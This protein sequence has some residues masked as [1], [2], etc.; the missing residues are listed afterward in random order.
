MICV[1]LFSLIFSIVNGFKPIWIG[2]TFRGQSFQSPAQNAILSENCGFQKTAKIKEF[3]WAVSF[4]VDGV[5]TLGGSI[6]SPYH[7]LTAAH[8]FITTIG[9]G[10][11]S[12]CTSVDLKNATRSVYR[13]IEFLRE[14]RKVAYGGKCIR[15]V[16]TEYPNDKKCQKPDVE[17]NKIRSVL[18]DGDFASSNCMDGHD[19][20]IVEV[21]NEIQ[22]GKNIMPICIPQRRMYYT[23]ALTVPGW[24]RSYR[25][26]PLI[27]EIPMHVDRKCK[28]PWSDRLP[29]DAKDYICATSMDTY[30]YSAP[31]TCHGDSG[32]GLEFRDDLGR[33]H[34]I[35]I[36][37]FGTRGCP[38]NM[39]ARFTSVEVY[40]DL[41]CKYTGVCY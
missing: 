33:A 29:Y 34:L 5:N 4:T 16:T 40:L 10:R 1:P 22:F 37:S 17:H 39:L 25:N 28:R 11:T 20:A 35:A 12:L 19:W 36:T 3:P 9:S 21:E 13:S 15:G 2:E 41:I 30:N 31:R 8:G 32:G 23:K 6:I 26:G 7:I 18:V 38:S 24:G 14:T 27:H